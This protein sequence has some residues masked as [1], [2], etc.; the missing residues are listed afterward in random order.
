[1]LFT[2]NDK[3]VDVA[4]MTTTYAGTGDYTVMKINTEK[5][6][7]KAFDSEYM[8][9]YRREVKFLAS[10]GIRYTFVKKTP[11]YGIRQYKY[12]KTPE[13]FIALAEFWA[14]IRNEK[15]Y[16]KI[17]SMVKKENT[18]SKE[19]EKEFIS[20]IASGDTNG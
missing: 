9:E 18:V 10:K 5:I 3:V 7:N 4:K 17:I 13:L 14:Q 2:E 19:A 20:N 15:V 11:D 12:T 16:N 8:T 6:P 1:M